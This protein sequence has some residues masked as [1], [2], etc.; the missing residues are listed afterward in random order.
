MCSGKSETG[1]ERYLSMLHDRCGYPNLTSAKLHLPSKMIGKLLVAVLLP[2]FALGA[3]IPKRET[4]A[5]DYDALSLR[6][7]GARN[8]LVSRPRLRRWGN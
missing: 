7:V 1:P 2:V 4:G 8:T 6:T 5:F 3:S